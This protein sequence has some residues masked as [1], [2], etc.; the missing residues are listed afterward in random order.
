MSRRGARP[1]TRSYPTFADGHDEMLVNDAIAESARTG[2]WVEVVRD[3]VADR[4]TTLED[5]TR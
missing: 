3:P 2:R 5:A 4:R 1:R